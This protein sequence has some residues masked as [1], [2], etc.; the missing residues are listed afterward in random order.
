MAGMETIRPI[1]LILIA[2][3]CGSRSSLDVPL[4]PAAPENGAP[5]GP[6]SAP[7]PAPGTGGIAD[8]G[9][10]LACSPDGAPL[11]LAT[12]VHYRDHIAVDSAYVYYSALD[13]NTVRRVPKGG[14]PSVTI[15]PLA[16]ERYLVDSGYVYWTSGTSPL[17]A[18]VFRISSESSSPESLA[19]AD[20]SPAP[21]IALDDHFVFV[22][23]SWGTVSRMPKS[24][25]TPVALADAPPPA[26]TDAVL[27]DG[28]NVYLAGDDGRLLAIPKTGGPTVLLAHGV[29]NASQMV[30]DA[31]FIYAQT[32]GLVRIPKDG[33][34]ATTLVADASPSAIAVDESFV[35]WT[36]NE[37]TVKDERVTLRKLPKSGGAPTTLWSA[38]FSSSVLAVDDSCLYLVRVRTTEYSL[39][40][41]P[42]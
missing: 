42:K 38:A 30:E 21:S 32:A 26:F 41:M 40:R 35:Y 19:T 11:V 17:G 14:G 31:R 4:V 29:I 8:A 12:N 23:P 28:S 6:G 33:S 3:A 37:G 39:V 7:S 18:S 27:A 36:A 1:L 16:G 2:T 34:Q 24:G 22:A 5:S 15:A 25:G 9:P 20:W 10:S 13:D